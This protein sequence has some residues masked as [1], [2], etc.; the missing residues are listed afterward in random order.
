MSDPNPGFF[1]KSRNINLLIAGLVV[2]CAGFVL[3]DLFIHNDHP[4]FELESQ[5]GFQAWFGFLAFVVIVFLGRGLRLFISRREDYYDVEETNE[6]SHPIEDQA[7][8][9][10]V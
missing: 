7:G 8:D 1:D 5:F 2:L 9:E 4:H 10:H 6:C 3:A